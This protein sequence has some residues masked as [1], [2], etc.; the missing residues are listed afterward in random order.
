MDAYFDCFS[1]ISGDMTLAAFV[2]LGVPVSFLLESIGRVLP[3][4]EFHIEERKANRN[5]I[6]AVDILVLESKSAP[7]RDYSAIQSLLHAGDLPPSVKEMSLAIFSRIAQAEA[8]IH[9]CPIDKVHFH[10]V[11]GVDAIVDIVGTALCVDF[12]KI[13][14]VSASRLPLGSGFVT[15]SHGR[16]PVPAPATLEILKN[17]PVQGTDI[18]H[19]LVTPTGAA[20][21]TTLAVEFHGMPDMKIEKIGYGAGK[22][23]MGDIPNLLRIMI[24]EKKKDR[25]IRADEKVEVLETCIDDMNPEIF[26]FIMERLFEDGALD[27]YWIPVYMKKNRPGTLI[28]VVCPASCRDKILDRILMET[29]TSGVR[30]YEMERRSLARRIVEIETSFGRLK[31]KQITKPDGVTIIVPEYEICRDI[32]I[33]KNIPVRVVYDT[34]CRESY[35]K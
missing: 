6:Q 9:G 16:L 24:G 15:C 14:S 19:E 35:G 1:G 21:I 5:G 18:Q 8:E 23:D 29:T 31:A 32:A 25:S 33:Q 12:L 10:E 4:K 3:K 2:D 22:R 7:S 11:G 26:G 30:F 13:S 27:V 20:I 34:I 28:Q 17:I